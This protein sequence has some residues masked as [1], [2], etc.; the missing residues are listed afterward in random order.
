MGGRG[1]GDGSLHSGLLALIRTRERER[2]GRTGEA[3][4]NRVSLLCCLHRRATTETSP[5]TLPLTLRQCF[6]L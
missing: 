3:V 1:S 6:F 2:G 4:S 5:L